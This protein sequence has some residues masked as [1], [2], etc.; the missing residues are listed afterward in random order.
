MRLALLL[1]FATV[2]AAE[3]YVRWIDKTGGVRRAP[4]S[5]VLAE[6]SAT[7]RVKTSKGD[8]VEIHTRSLLELVRENETD[9]DQRALL[10]ARIAVRHAAA[11]AAAPAEAAATLDRL[12]ATAKHAWMREYAAAFRAILAERKTEKDAGKRIDAFLEAHPRSRFRAEV[13]RA[14]ARLKSHGLSSFEDA[15]RPFAEVFEQI[16]QER[17]PLLMQYRVWVDS[18]HRVLEI[19][20]IDFNTFSKSIESSLGGRAGADPHPEDLLVLE[21]AVVWVQLV[22]ETA[23]REKIVS[24]GLKPHG[25]L[26]EVLKLCRACDLLLPELRSDVHYELGMIYDACGDPKKAAE[27]FHEALKLAPDAWRRD[28]ATKKTQPQ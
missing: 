2:A 10:A 19:G 7:I 22:R 1:L 24:Q 13:Q 16:E 11:P 27:H 26:S 9:A 8:T 3:P 6:D 18:S 28:R 17:G 4:I 14:Q 21:S 15:L 20:D 5:A 12:A 25:P 23:R